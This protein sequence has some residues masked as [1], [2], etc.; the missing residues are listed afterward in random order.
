MF[1]IGVRLMDKSWNC[2][3]RMRRDKDRKISI[4]GIQENLLFFLEG[5]EILNVDFLD[6]LLEFLHKSSLLHRD[7][8]R[9]TNFFKIEPTL[10]VNSDLFK[11]SLSPSMSF[12]RLRDCIRHGFDF[13]DGSVFE[14]LGMEEFETRLILFMNKSFDKF[15]SVVHL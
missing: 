10:E 1:F 11:E 13:I 5:V 14:I 2:E 12:Q 7:F 15:L 8:T 4:F 3:M 6:I 9:S